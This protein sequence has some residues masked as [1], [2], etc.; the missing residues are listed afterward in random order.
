MSES[1]NQHENAEPAMQ[2]SAINVRLWPAVVF[3]LIHIAALVY[4]LFFTDTLFQFLAGSMLIPLLV[5]IGLLI[6]WMLCRRIPVKQRLAGVLLLISTLAWIIFTHPPSTG[7]FSFLVVVLPIINIGTAT[8][9]AVT[10]NQPWPRRRSALIAFMFG[11]AIV[12]TAVRVDGSYGNETPMMSWRWT[13]TAEELAEASFDS[14]AQANRIASVSAQADSKDWPGFRGPNRDNRAAGV[15]FA[16]NWAD[17]APQ[18]LWRQPI[19]IGWSSFAV[20]GNYFFTQE[21]RGENELVVCYEVAT[22]DQV[23]INS[24]AGRFDEAHGGGPRATPTF[25]EGKLYTLGALGTLQCLEASTGE[26]VWKRDLT[27]DANVEVPMWGF[28]NSPLVV[29]GNVVVFAGGEGGKSVWAYRLESGDPVWQAGDGTH[30]YSSVHFAAIDDIPQL[31]APSN[32]GIQSFAPDTGKLLWEFKKTTPIDDAAQ[33]QPLLSG[34]NTILLGSEMLGTRSLEVRNSGPDCTVEEQWANEKF[35]PSFHD[36]VYHE[37]FAYGFDGRRFVC[38]DMKTGDQ[39]W[40]SKRHGGQVLLLPD[41]N[42]LLILSDKGNVILIEATPDAHREIA[43]FEALDGKTWNHP[44]VSQG[45]LFVRNSEEA[46]CY[47][48][49]VPKGK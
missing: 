13:Q 20:I 47:Q 4:A 12:L 9:F 49:P 40:K 41:M 16:T 14:D 37:G 2:P 8:V 17:N 6:W 44:V 27:E 25:H 48:L 35:R 31:L 24:V 38:I 22:G 45:K 7:G 23:W 39:R 11:T 21:Q 28:S 32:F 3:A 1:I 42:M 30:S 43:Q 26:T 5:L 36:A 29:D 10:L 34:S 15:T 46:A 18:E 33:V 19:G